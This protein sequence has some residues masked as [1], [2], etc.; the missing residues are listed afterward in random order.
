MTTDEII[1]QACDRLNLPALGRE[2][3]KRVAASQPSRSVRSNGANVVCRFPSMKMGVTIQAE[4]HSCELA[5][6]YVLEHDPSVIGYWDQPEPIKIS[7]ISA[8]GRAVSPTITPDFLVLRSDSVE[9]IEAKLNE[10]LPDLAKEM[11]NRFILGD[12]CKWHSPPAEATAQGHGF[13][14]RIWTPADVDPT[15]LKNIKFLQTYFGTDVGTVPPEIKEQTIEVLHTSPGLS[16]ADLRQRCPSA[17]ADHINLLLAHEEIYADLAAALLTDQSKVQVF[18]CREMAETFFQLQKANYVGGRD[19]GETSVLTTSS[20]PQFSATAMQILFEASPKDHFI[21]NY[22][23]RVLTEIDHVQKH[24]TPRR[25]IRRW[26]KLFSDAQEIH[27]HGMFGLFPKYKDRGNRIPR[28]P[29]KLL[30]LVDKV[31]EEDYCTP[32]RPNKQYAYNQFLLRCENKYGIVPCKSW[33]N[34]RISNRSKFN[35]TLARQGKRA[36]HKYE[37]FRPGEPNDN[38][39]SFPWEVCHTDHT[40]CDVELVCS[41][42]GENLGRPWLSVLIDG[43][44]RRILAFCLTFDPP[45]YRTLMMLI[46]DCVKRHNRLPGCLVVDGGKEFRSTYFEALTAFYGV[47]IK[48]RPPAKARFGSLIER[49]F[50]TVNSQFFHALAGNTQNTRNVRQLTKSMDP[51]GHAIYTLEDM[52]SMFSIY[53]FEHY[54]KRPHPALNFTPAEKFA[55]GITAFGA[56]EHQVIKDNEAFRLMTLPSTSKGMAKI[57]PGMGVKLF[58]FYFWSDQM[59]SQKFEGKSVRVKYDPENLGVSWAYLDDWVKCRPSQALK[60][61][62]R[63]EKELRIAAQEWRRSSQL[64]EHRQSGSH[65]N[66]AEFLQTTQQNKTL[67][68][69][70]AKDR[71]LRNTRVEAIHIP[72]LSPAENLAGPVVPEV[73]FPPS[74][75]LATPVEDYGNF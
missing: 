42:T 17:T 62:G 2:Y 20:T 68:L 34:K 70:Q 46:R 14:F 56:R 38:H 25:T 32:T 67:L 7:Y 11:P 47:M 69:Q 59:R 57:Q 5:L 45:S 54:N 21:A 49:F 63:T 10:A 75:P 65:R 26:H 8:T 12:D 6:I 36:A 52:N 66:L 71:A 29:E 37:I 24:S 31:I 55:E 58:G 3:L 33:F 51:K 23:F 13:R 41:A 43:Y 44:S 16:L 35:D 39:G 50:G 40:L 19:N 18:T 61:D 4:S 22:R 28:F 30:D 64:L 48:R 1:I 27:G 60:L 72:A 73:A 53:A 15:W 9:L 74:L